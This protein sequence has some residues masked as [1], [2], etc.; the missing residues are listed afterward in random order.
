MSS[1]VGGP[2][3]TMAE[4]DG[5][6]YIDISSDSDSDGSYPDNDSRSS[7]SICPYRTAE[8]HDRE[9]RRFFD[10]PTHIV[11]RNLSDTE[12]EA[13][14]DVAMNHSD[15]RPETQPDTVTGDHIDSRLP[16]AE[17]RGFAPVDGARI[18]SLPLRS[19][20]AHDAGHSETV[21]TLVNQQ[22]DVASTPASE[23][24]TQLRETQDAVPSVSSIPSPEPQVALADHPPR[25]SSLPRPEVID[26]TRDATPPMPALLGS[27]LVARRGSERGSITSNRSQQQPAE[28]RNGSSE[29]VLPRWQPDAEV[30]FCP[31]CRT[32]FSF[33]VRK[34]HCRKCGRVVCNACSPHRITIPYQYIVQPI[35]QPRHAA[36]RYPSSLISGEGGYADF[37]S[38]GGG[39]RVRLCNPC[40]PD[41]NTSPP[42]PRGSP[43]QLS[44]RVA[45]QRARSNMDSAVTGD[46]PSGRFQG[47]F[48]ATPGQDAF[49]RSRSVTHSGPGVG[50]STARATYIGAQNRIPVGTPTTY[51]PASSSAS[52]YPG[53]AQSRYRSMLDV[54]SSSSSAAQNR[55]L[56]PPPPPLAEEDE[57]P[58]CHRELPPRHL[59]D[60]EALREAHITICITSHSRYPG[61][62]GGTPGETPQDSVAGTPPPLAARRTGMFPYVA[63]EKDCVDSAECTICLEEFVA[64]VQMARLE[65]LCRFHRSCISAWFVN[66]PGR[67]PVHQHDSYGY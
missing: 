14:D 10:C 56:P 41:P 57:C 20:S 27:P 59:P 13:V 19:N 18:G 21:H 66:H 40:V 31:I 55:A 5:R 60:F 47:Y 16:L 58:I 7:S 9:C 8:Y 32:Q 39:E 51:F 22:P 34:H 26:L 2:G 12:D 37:S 67:C 28:G 29:I 62:G 33:F 25:T 35:E 11:E 49:V 52:A 46:P 45:H 6:Q 48:S 53:A 63:T 43:A 64:G 54:G 65:C 15:P 23:I 50:S 24:S 3:S 61:G 4:N 38:L 17:S 30:T 42:Q 1:S 36:Q 44:P